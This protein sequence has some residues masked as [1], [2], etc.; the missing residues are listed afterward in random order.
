MR[1]LEPCQLCGEMHDLEALIE[2]GGM[3]VCGECLDTSTIRCDRCGRQLWRSENAGDSDTYLCDSCFENYYTNCSHC[4]ALIR[5]EDAHYEDEDTPL[6]YDCY[7]QRM[8]RY[9]IQ[10]YGFKPDTALYYFV[11]LDTP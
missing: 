6:C 1:D 3:R 10:P 5:E 7:R 11:P 2:F 9:T 8:N 4:G